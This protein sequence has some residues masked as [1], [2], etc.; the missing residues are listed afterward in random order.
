LAEQLGHRRRDAGTAVPQVIVTRNAVRGIQRC[1]TFLAAKAPDAARRAGQTIDRYLVSLA[2]HPDIGRPFSDGLDLRELLI[3]FGHS[4][5]A[6]PYRHV[7][8]KT[9]V[10]VLAFRHQKEAGYLLP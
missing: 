9:A 10:Y 2:S 5:Y 8:G 6:A 4:G 1:Q 3:P 7:P